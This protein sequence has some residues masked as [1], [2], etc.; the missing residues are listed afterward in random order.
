MQKILFLCIASLLMLSLV[1][2][3]ISLIAQQH[4]DP[5]A[6]AILI[7]ENRSNERQR[8]KQLNETNDNQNSFTKNLLSPEQSNSINNS[9]P[10][11]TGG[12]TTA[13]LGDHGDY[14]LYNSLTI[15]YEDAEDYRYL[16]ETC[17][18]CGII[19]SLMK[20]SMQFGGKPIVLGAQGMFEKFDGDNVAFI[21][22]HILAI[23]NACSECAGAILYAGRY[24][25]LTLSIESIDEF[26]DGKYQSGY[27]DSI[28]AARSDPE[29]AYFFP[30]NSKYE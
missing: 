7:N 16:L 17:S 24:G 19:L 3:V 2:Q 18:T 22:N 15:Y 6:L 1:F 5:D 21:Y 25:D 23:A 12:D 30:D 14:T 9:E 29:Y 4:N 28:Q 8:Y 20:A 10:V 26:V 13:E 11:D 27:M